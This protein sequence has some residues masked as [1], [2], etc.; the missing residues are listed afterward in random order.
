MQISHIHI[1]TWNLRPVCTIIIVCKLALRDIKLKLIANT[2]CYVTI[3]RLYA[4][5]CLYWLMG[6]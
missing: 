1:D 2:Y 4:H 5:Q 6:S 3:T